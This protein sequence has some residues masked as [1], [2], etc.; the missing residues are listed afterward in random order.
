MKPAVGQVWYSPD[1]DEIHVITMWG[2]GLF[3]TQF[4]DDDFG[5]QGWVDFVS[6]WPTYWVYLGDV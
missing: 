1:L 2:K 3:Y 4:F 6:E 5:G